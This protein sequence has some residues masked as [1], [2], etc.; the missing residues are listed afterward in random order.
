[1]EHSCV[2]WTAISLMLSESVYQDW[3]TQQYCIR[4]LLLWKQKVCNGWPW[5]WWTLWVI[6]KVKVARVTSW[7]FLGSTY[8]LCTTK[9]FIKHHIKLG[10][11]LA[12]L[13]M[14]H[15][16]DLY[17]WVL[18][19]PELL[20]WA[21]APFSDGTSAANSVSQSFTEGCLFPPPILTTYDV[22]CNFR[23]KSI[24]WV[25]RMLWWIPQGGL[26]W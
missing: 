22:I 8:M 16:Y 10:R 26:R 6:N 1:M 13:P 23:R 19:V 25:W 7:N 15:L 24:Y 20:F 21:V 4:G 11:M 17:R 9:S 2:T 3:Y 18:P 12:L 14:V 5:P